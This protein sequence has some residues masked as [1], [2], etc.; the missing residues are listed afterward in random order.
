MDLPERESC[1]PGEG[2][3][4]SGTFAVVGYRTMSRAG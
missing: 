1:D 3:S 2:K 4:M